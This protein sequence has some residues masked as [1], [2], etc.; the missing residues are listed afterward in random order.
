VGWDKNTRGTTTL[1]KET[2][3]VTLHPG[4]IKREERFK[5][6]K[7]WNPKTALLLLKLQSPRL[8]TKSYRL[9]PK[10]VFV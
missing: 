9:A 6:S 8:H 4:N 7:A 1:I 10:S 2:L 5:L 3:D